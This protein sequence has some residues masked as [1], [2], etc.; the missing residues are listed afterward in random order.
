MRL[1]FFLSI[2]ITIFSATNQSFAATFRSESAYFSPEV[3]EALDEARKRTSD[4]FTKTIVKIDPVLVS[5]DFQREQINIQQ[6]GEIARNRM[7]DELSQNGLSTEDATRAI[8]ESIVSPSEYDLWLILKSF[9]Q[10][11]QAVLEEITTSGDL[12]VAQFHAVEA[13]QRL[14]F[15]AMFGSPLDLETVETFVHKPSINGGTYITRIQ[16]NL[17]V[18]L[19]DYWLKTWVEH[20]DMDLS[21]ARALL[22]S[23][24]ALPPNVVAAIREKTNFNGIHTAYDF[25]RMT[26]GSLYPRVRELYFEL[27]ENA[28]NTTFRKELTGKAF[29]EAQEKYLAS[30]HIAPEAKLA[31]QRQL[32]GEKTGKVVD[33]S[34]MVD[35]PS[36]LNAKVK[37]FAEQHSVA[38]CRTPQ[39]GS[40]TIHVFNTSGQKIAEYGYIISKRASLGGPGLSAALIDSTPGSQDPALLINDLDYYI[41]RKK[42][43]ILHNFISGDWSLSGPVPFDYFPIF[44]REYAERCLSRSSK[45]VK[46]YSYERV[47]VDAYGNKVAGYA[48]PGGEIIL[49]AAFYDRSIGYFKKGLNA[50]LFGIVPANEAEQVIDAVFA[51]ESCSSPAIQTF[52]S[53]LLRFFASNNPEA[54]RA[55]DLDRSA[56]YYLKRGRKAFPDSQDLFKDVSVASFETKAAQQRQEALQAIKTLKTTK[57]AP[58]RLQSFEGVSE[59][60]LPGRLWLKKRGKAT[61]RFRMDLNQKI[62]DTEIMESDQPQYLVGAAAIELLR[63][64]DLSDELSAYRWDEYTYFIVEIMAIPTEQMRKRYG[65]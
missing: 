41:S 22:G 17:L 43:A 18:F 35:D 12:W 23:G 48:G 33:Y 8:F 16:V 11:E 50:P 27:K 7:V 21:S 5:P 39:N 29:F 56:E 62:T 52:R 57:D 25:M 55:P 49:D 28:E 54:R 34:F 30:P 61:I 42:A 60:M 6:I 36:G 24:S 3:Y 4:T 40:C 64:R 32:N 45:D 65:E 15:N 1:I 19:N 47:K 51:K 58:F 26:N 46:T 37:K 53:Q 10:P 2:V 20:R 31:F 38:R 14:Q 44:G 63:K 9:G 13:H 59:G